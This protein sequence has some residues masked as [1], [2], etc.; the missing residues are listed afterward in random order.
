M[1]QGVIGYDAVELHRETSPGV[2]AKIGDTRDINGPG[3][4]RD[5][6]ETTTRDSPN[7]YKEFIGGLRDGGEVTVDITYSKTGSAY[8]DLLADFHE[9]TAHNY[10]L[11][12]VDGTS[13]E[14]QFAALVTGM[15]LQAPLD[16]KLSLT[17]PMKITGKPV[18]VAS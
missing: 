7:G 13:R 10:K 18:L 11:K 8:T 15:P 3:L 2:Y 1:T 9:N 17:V 6:H 16:D 12:F 5:T 4:T 14:W